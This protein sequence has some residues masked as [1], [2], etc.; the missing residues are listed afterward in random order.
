MC[1]FRT[2]HYKADFSYLPYHEEL[3]KRIAVVSDLHNN[4]YGRN[5]EHLL[6]AIQAENPS[7]I[8]ITG[9][10]VVNDRREN[11]R[12]LKFLK[13]LSKLKLPIIYSLG[14]HEERFRRRDA[15]AYQ[16]YVK[17]L[18]ALGVQY[19]DNAWF[20]LTKH[21]HIGGLTVPYRCYQRGFGVKLQ[22][23]ELE[24]LLPKRDGI[25]IVLAHDP[26]WFPVYR[27]CG[28]DI[29]LSGHLHGGIV[30]LPRL[31]GLISTRLRLF[32][33]YDA[34]MFRERNSTM[35]V[36][37]GLGSHTIKLRINNK[38]ELMMIDLQ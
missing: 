28:Y 27:D 8:L 3:P 5:N 31:G 17:H 23:E 1:P 18:K 7:L 14:N 20:D 38:P 35:F 11:G 9:D 13:E 12:A 29:I 4:I 32:P 10:L 36:S 22:K 21:V 34:G 37:R 25:R 33:K 2:E 26:H 16:K 19:L 6:S 15:V 24:E 30:R